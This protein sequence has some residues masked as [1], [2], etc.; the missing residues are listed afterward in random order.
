MQT[1][2]DLR[3][4]AGLGRRSMVD[5]RAAQVLDPGRERRLVGEELVRVGKIEKAID[6]RRQQPRESLARH[7]R[8]RTARVFTREHAAGNDPV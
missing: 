6:S 1:I 7:L 2:E 5:Y 8:R 4:H 3:H